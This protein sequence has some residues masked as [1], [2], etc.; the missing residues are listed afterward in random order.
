PGPVRLLH[1]D[2]PLRALP[3]VLERGL[4][5]EHHV[6]AVGRAR[7]LRRVIHGLD[8]PSDGP[9]QR[10]LRGLER[11][12][13][14]RLVDRLLEKARGGRPARRSVAPVDQGKP[15]LGGGQRFGFRSPIRHGYL[16]CD[17]VGAARTGFTRAG[18]ARVPRRLGPAFSSGPPAAV[19]YLPPAACRRP[20]PYLPPAAT[21]TRPGAGRTGTI[22]RPGNFQVSA[23]R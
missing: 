6:L 3:F 22:T 5:L 20:R 9:A 10:P 15:A 8:A 7:E 18:R 17:S 16:L 1:H 14:P 2:H 13:P 4:V 11:L 23:P 21:A 19:L 12:R